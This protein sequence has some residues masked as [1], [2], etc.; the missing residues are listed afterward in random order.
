[1]P[2]SED[3][4]L[5]AAGEVSEDRSPRTVKTSLKGDTW[6]AKGSL[7][8]RTLGFSGKGVGILRSGRDEVGSQ[9]SRLWWRGRRF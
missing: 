6:G 4:Q 5:L 2:G 9:G 7:G 8:A 1:M 3:T